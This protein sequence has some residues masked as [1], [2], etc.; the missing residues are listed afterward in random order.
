MVVLSNYDFKYLTV[1]IIKPEE[2]FINL[3]ANKCLKSESTISSTRRMRI[4]L[5]A[6]YENT[7][8]NKFMK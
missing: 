2:S 1:N 5:D 6:K 4:I 7:D 3:C 8:L